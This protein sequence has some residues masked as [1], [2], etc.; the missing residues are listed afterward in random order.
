MSGIVA[1]GKAEMSFLRQCLAMKSRSL[2]EL[3]KVIVKV[4]DVDFLE[5]GQRDVVK[6]VHASTKN[7]EIP[8]NR[9][10]ASWLGS[11]P[12]MDDVG[13]TKKTVERALDEKLPTDRMYETSTGKLTQRSIKL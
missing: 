1:V 8:R 4:E 13:G 9:N 3:F 2:E 5:Y 7:A 12:S 6:K 10:G 11:F